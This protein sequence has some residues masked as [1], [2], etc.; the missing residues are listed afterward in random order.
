MGLFLEP[1]YFS[2]LGKLLD[3]PYFL[4]FFCA[5]S[6]YGLRIRRLLQYLFLTSDVTMT[7]EV[8]SKYIYFGEGVASAGDVNGDGYAD[9]IVGATRFNSY[10]GRAYVY[11]GGSSIDNSAD[12]TMTG[13]DYYTG[14]G[15]AVASAGD[16]NGDGYTDAIMG[17][18][19]Y[20]SSRG[21]AYIYYGGSSMDNSADVTMTGEAM[22]NFFGYSVASAGNVNGH[23]DGAGKGR[24]ANYRVTASLECVPEDRRAWASSSVG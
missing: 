17:A 23:R 6:L 3:C 11:Y 2:I 8:P 14:F 5:P 18:S 10:Q 4:V 7:G 12:V 19:E 9:T 22:S 1:R 15:L 13:E 20:D 21:R 16:L 24:E